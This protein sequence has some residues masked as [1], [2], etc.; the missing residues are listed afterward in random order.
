MNRLH[1][2]AELTGLD[3]ALPHDAALFLVAVS[4]RS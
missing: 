3:L 1:R 4:G 2:L